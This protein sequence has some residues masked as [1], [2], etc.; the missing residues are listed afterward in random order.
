[1]FLSVFRLVCVHSAIPWTRQS[2]IIHERRS[3]RKS[4]GENDESQVCCFCTRGFFGMDQALATTPS[5]CCCGALL[6][7][8]QQEIRALRAELACHVTCTHCGQLYDKR[9]AMGVC[10]VTGTTH[11]DP[12]FER[13]TVCQAVVPVHAQQFRMS[14]FLDGVECVHRFHTSSSSAW[15]RTA[16][17]MLRSQRSWSGGMCQ[18]ELQGAPQH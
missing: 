9:C 11:N 4:G 15:G 1:V 8:L 16:L 18:S 6:R 5:T 12:D 7:E 14:E 17:A 2:H 10:A 13:C 3:Q